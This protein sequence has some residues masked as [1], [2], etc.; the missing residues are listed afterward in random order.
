MITPTPLATVLPEMPP[1]NVF[2]WVELPM[3]VMLASLE[4]P[5]TLAPMMM[6]LLPVVRFDPAPSPSATLFP[7]VV[8]LASAPFPVAVLLLPVVFLNNA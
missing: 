2:F 7:P 4:L 5:T 1:I 8:L 6:L 3:R